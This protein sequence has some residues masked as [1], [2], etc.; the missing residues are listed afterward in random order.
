MT[1]VRPVLVGIGLLVV[2]QALVWATSVP[3][4]NITSVERRRT[5]SSRTIGSRECLSQFTRMMVTAR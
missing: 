1:A 3:P 4:L 2:W 5:W